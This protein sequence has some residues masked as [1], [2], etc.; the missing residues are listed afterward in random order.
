MDMQR[1][2]WFV[3]SGI[4]FKSFEPNAIAMQRSMLGI[5]RRVAKFTRICTVK[6][7]VSWEYS[8]TI[9]HCVQSVWKYD[10]SSLRAQ[11]CSDAV[12]MSSVFLCFVLCCF[13]M[14]LH[15]IALENGCCSNAIIIIHLCNGWLVIAAVIIKDRSKV[16]KSTVAHKNQLFNV[17]HFEQKT[18]IR[19]YLYSRPTRTESNR[20]FYL[21]GR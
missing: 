10:H 2:Q 19:L 9:F 4:A 15:W 1:L 18:D 21:S 7:I 3:R 20:L 14:L 13:S 17:T 16:Y 11:S 12:S 5:Y 6:E 8:V